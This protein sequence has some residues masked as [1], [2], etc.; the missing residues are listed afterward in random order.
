M[1]ETPWVPVLWFVAIVALIP[2]ALWLLRR[3]PVGGTMAASGLRTVGQLPLSASQ[4]VVTIEIGS[5]D[6]R[7]WLVLG[8]TPQQIRTLH[9]M[10]PQPGSATAA[11]AGAG[12]GF[13]QV[14]G[15][16]RDGGGGTHAR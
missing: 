13:A 1:T 6:D 5:G 10:R 4:R 11:P 3:S 2:V 15:R 8:V 7:T 12:S 9:T 14:L 16:L